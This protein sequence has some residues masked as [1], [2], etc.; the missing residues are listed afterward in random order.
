MKNAGGNTSTSKRRIGRGLREQVG[1]VR[2]G[3]FEVFFVAGDLGSGGDEFG[4]DVGVGVV[5]DGED[6]GD[7]AV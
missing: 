6:L 2:C 1:E 3:V 5:A 4:E 7:A